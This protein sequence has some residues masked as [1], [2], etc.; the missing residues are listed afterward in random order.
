MCV[1]F[2]FIMSFIQL[3][4]IHCNL[5]L[6]QGQ[7]NY[8]YYCYYYKLLLLISHIHHVYISVDAQITIAIVYRYH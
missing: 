5:F 4:F 3:P 8:Y 1:C 2:I 6:A 7:I